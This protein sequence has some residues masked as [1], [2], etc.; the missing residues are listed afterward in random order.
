MV[1]TKLS[2]CELATPF[3]IHRILGYSV[4]HLVTNTNPISANPP[5]PPTSTHTLV[6]LLFQT[7]GI[8]NTSKNIF[9]KVNSVQIT[10]VSY[11]P[12]LISAVIVLVSIHYAKLYCYINLHCRCVMQGM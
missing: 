2:K 1:H 10:T 9:G 4:L 3:H 5:V 8:Q 6:L 11:E 7:F 12:S